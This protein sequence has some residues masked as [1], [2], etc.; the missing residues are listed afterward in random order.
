MRALL[1][2]DFWLLIAAGLVAFT[3]SL[4]IGAWRRSR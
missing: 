1:A 4:H 3:V 2:S